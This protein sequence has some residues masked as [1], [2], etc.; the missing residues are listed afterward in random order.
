MRRGAP[1]ASLP[2]LSPL[3]H[4]VPGVIDLVDLVTSAQDNGEE[5]YSEGKYGDKETFLESFVDLPRLLISIVATATFAT[6]IIRIC[7]PNK[8][9]RRCPVR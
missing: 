4:Q 6:M 3:Y 9:L 5:T 8:S 7:L 2:L 1:P